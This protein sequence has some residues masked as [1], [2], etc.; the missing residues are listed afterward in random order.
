VDALDAQKVKLFDG[1]GVNL[2]E[3]VDDRDID[4]AASLAIELCGWTLC[5]TDCPQ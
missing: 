4:P 1:D 5:L 2:V 3:D